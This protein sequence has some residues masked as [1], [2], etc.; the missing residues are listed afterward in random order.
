MADTGTP[1]G[2][3]GGVTTINDG[4]ATDCSTV[5]NWV[6]LTDATDCGDDGNNSSLMARTSGACTLTSTNAGKFMANLSISIGGT[7]GH[8]IYFGISVNDALPSLGCQGVITV[9][10]GATSMER[11]AISCGIAP[12][13]GQTIKARFCNASSSAASVDIKRMTLNVG[14]R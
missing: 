4:A 7:A 11:G 13:A 14:Q 10:S 2:D 3:I 8:N 6:H 1:Y 12:T 9:P 5:A